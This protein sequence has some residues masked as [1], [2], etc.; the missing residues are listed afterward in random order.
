VVEAGRRSGALITARMAAEEHGREVMA[1]P[2]R[3][4]SAASLGALELI[5]D[6]GAALVTSPGDVLALLETPARHT[7]AGTHAA[8]YADPARTAESLFVDRPPEAPAPDGVAGR[9]Q[10]PTL[11][12]RQQAILKALAEPLTLDELVRATSLDPAAL[13]AEITAL[14]I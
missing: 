14:E 11:S 5:R 12:E 10:P 4:D 2:G 7:F 9:N 6:G 1:V 8:R 13:R 3:V